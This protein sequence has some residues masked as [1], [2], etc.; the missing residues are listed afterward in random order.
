[1]NVTEMQMSK[2]IMCGV[3]RLDRIRND[4]MKEG[5]FKSNGEGKRERIDCDD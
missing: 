3:S 2:L 4:Y 1:M 5:E